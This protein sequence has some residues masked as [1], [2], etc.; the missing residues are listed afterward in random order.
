MRTKKGKCLCVWLPT[1]KIFQHFQDLK[2]K[3][4]FTA[5]L[6]GLSESV[7]ACSISCL[8]TF[9]CLFTN[10]SVMCVYVLLWMASWVLSRNVR[11][12]VCLCTSAS[13]FLVTVNKCACVCELFEAAVFYCK[14]NGWKA[15]CPMAN[16]LQVWLLFR[17]GMNDLQLQRL[18]NGC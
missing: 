15:L 2:K 5:T 7:C 3:F 14:G 10:L 17:D 9:V 18:C 16:T 8:L 11:I 12:C 4:N 6:G 1:P 13:V